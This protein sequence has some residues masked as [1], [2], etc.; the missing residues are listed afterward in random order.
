MAM[1][2][3]DDISELGTID[4]VEATPDD[5]VEFGKIPDKEVVPLAGK[6]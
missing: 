1:E 4:D 2:L 3:V 5:T 6:F